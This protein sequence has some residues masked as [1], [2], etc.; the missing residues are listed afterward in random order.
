M[1]GKDKGFWVK[2]SATMKIKVFGWLLLSDLL[3]TRNMLKRRHYKIGDNYGCILCGTN[4][5]ETLEHMIFHCPFSKACW[6][7]LHIHWATQGDR[8]FWIQEAKTAWNNPMFMEIFLYASWSLWKERNNKHFRGIAPSIASWFARFKEDL[9]L[10][11]HRV[12][13]AHRAA[14]LSYCDTLS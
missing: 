3:N 10:L 12:K 1:H 5:E 6:D 14:L 4:D 8:L 7:T 2:S 11:Q 9:R 13:V